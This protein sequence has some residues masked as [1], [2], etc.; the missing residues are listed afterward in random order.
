M[1]GSL[2]YQ[3]KGGVLNGSPLPETVAIHTSLRS[4]FF[5]EDEMFSANEELITRA[6]MF[7]G[8][9]GVRQ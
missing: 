5:P 2:L 7:I 9:V 6:R 1:K 8:S 4:F 3:I